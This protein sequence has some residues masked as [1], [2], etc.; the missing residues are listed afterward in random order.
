MLFVIYG[1]TLELGFKS[2][3]YFQKCGFHIIKKY[4]SLCS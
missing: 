4:R 3:E 2:R 1:S